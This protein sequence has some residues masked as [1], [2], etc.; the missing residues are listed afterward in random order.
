MSDDKVNMAL[1]DII[2]LNKRKR[3]GQSSG[4]NN[5]RV[6]QV[7]GRTF[8]GNRGRGGLAQRRGARSNIVQRRGARSEPV[9]RRGARSDSASVSAVNNAA[10]RRFVKNLVNKTLQR[11]RAKAATAAGV[12][13]RRAVRADAAIA[14]VNVRSRGIRKRVVEVPR[15][16]VR[17]PR[18]RAAVQRQVVE[19]EPEPVVYQAVRVV[20]REPRAVRPVA[21][22]RARPVRQDHRRPDQR[23]VDFRRPDQRGVDFRRPDQRGVDFRRPQQRGVDFRR[24]NQRGVQNAQ[25]GRAQMLPV[26]RFVQQPSAQLAVPRQRSRIIVQQPVRASGGFVRRNQVFANGGGRQN[27]RANVIYVNEE[28]SSRVQPSARSGVRFV[29]KRPNRQFVEYEDDVEEYDRF[30]S[31][32]FQGNRRTKRKGR[33][34]TTQYDY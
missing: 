22:V 14:R 34:F 27:Q 1:D 11:M 6:R 7:K 28:L 8:V 13:N 15:V 20:K 4:R 33:G 17:R 24:P 19:E 29:N 21:V 23:G 5:D 2:K 3:S 30:P 32:S 18:I 16:I 9:Q 31:T 26:R 25:N 12:V 10:T